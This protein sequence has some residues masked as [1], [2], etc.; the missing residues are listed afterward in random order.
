MVLIIDIL[1]TLKQPF[2]TPS[3]QGLNWSFLLKILLPKTGTCT[4]CRTTKLKMPSLLHCKGYG[5]SKKPQNIMPK[6]R[7]YQINKMKQSHIVTT[8]FLGH[9]KHLSKTQ[10]VVMRFKPCPGVDTSNPGEFIYLGICE[11]VSVT[12]TSKRMRSWSQFCLKRL[13]PSLVADFKIC[14]LLHRFPLFSLDNL[15]QILHG[16]TEAAEP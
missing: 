2:S 7:E 6:I 12:K 10:L 13:S 9:T 14:I 15:D 8:R 11:K 3:E 16:V 4:E 1:V 5:Q